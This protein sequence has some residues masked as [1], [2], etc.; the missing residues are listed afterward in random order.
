MA[1]RNAEA[2][3]Q[4]T[5][6]E[7]NGNMKVGSGALDV[8]FSFKS[9]FT[10]GDPMTNPEELIGAAHAGCFTMALNN[11]LFKEGLTPTR[12]HTV[13]HVQMGQTDAGTTITQID[14]VTE[15]E[16]PGLDQAAFAAHAEAT[17]DTCIVS[18]ALASVPM[19]IQATLNS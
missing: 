4:G 7:G 5:L 13:A 10:E 17:K 1:T 9:R 18:R 11:R 3:W 6:S 15:G 19:T 14:L 12:I 2:T 16:V 8:P